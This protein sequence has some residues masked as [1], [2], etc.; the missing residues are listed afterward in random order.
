[1]ANWINLFEKYRIDKRLLELRLC[2]LGALSKSSPKRPPLEAMVQQIQYDLH[3]AER[4]L[5]RYG[6]AASSARDALQRAD[7]RLFLAFHYIRGLTMEETATEMCISRDSVYRIRRRV[8][9]RGE[10][11]S[12][13]IDEAGLTSL[14]SFHNDDFPLEPRR[15]VLAACFAGAPQEAYDSLIS[16][17]P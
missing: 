4:V 1:M 5:S 9:A 16:S 10:I 14:R 8:L 11:P 6:D 17:C 12:E 13:Y 7:E 15:N 3:A 2:E